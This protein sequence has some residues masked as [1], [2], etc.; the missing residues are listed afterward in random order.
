MP[1]E[2]IDQR[3]VVVAAIVLRD[4]HLVV[5]AVP[6]AGP[7]LVRPHQAEREI[8]R[9][10]RQ[11]RLE[12][13]LQQPAAVEPVEIL[14]EAKQPGRARHFYL[15]P[16]HR[17][18]VGRGAQRVMPKI[19]WDARLI[20]PLEPRHGARDRGPFGE[21][22][23]PPGVV[24]RH[25]MELRQVIGEHFRAPHRAPRQCVKILEVRPGP[26][27]FLHLLEHPGVGRRRFRVQLQPMPVLPVMQQ[28]VLP[29]VAIQVAAQVE[30]GIELGRGIAPLAV[31]IQQIMLERIDPGRRDVVD[32]WPGRSCGKFRQR[33]DTAAGAMPQVMRQQRQPGL[34]A[35]LGGV[36]GK[37]EKWPR[38]TPLGLAADDVVPQRIAPRPRHVGVLL[39][40]PLGVEI[41][42]RA[43]TLP[44]AA[45]QEVLQRI[46]PAAADVGIGLQVP[47]R[48][49]QPRRRHGATIVGIH[50]AERVGARTI[51]AIRPDAAA[52]HA[53]L[54]SEPGRPRMRHVFGPR[55][56]SKPLIH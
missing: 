48:I 11:I 32:T 26:G 40:V 56:R 4:Q 52:G 15:L 41:P 30:F 2:G 17:Y 6:P 46:G 20:M 37:L 43:A 10:F 34:R 16:H 8:E 39:Q 3:G 38:R 28:R 5:R 36:P 22:V 53:M 23:A 19:A 50:G 31:A 35:M 47:C 42:V 14:H 21:A 49:E 55:R 7:V 44:P 51:L 25:G 54:F 13:R 24:L 33:A 18:A 9:R 1:G 12:R 45:R 27:E 29:G